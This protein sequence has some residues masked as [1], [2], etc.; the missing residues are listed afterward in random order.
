MQ[1]D[2]DVV[3]SNL[4]SLEGHGEDG[5]VATGLDRG[6]WKQLG[7]AA[8]KNRDALNARVNEAMHNG[9]A[10]LEFDGVA[11][12]EALLDALDAPV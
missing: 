5:A 2:D 9:P 1:V 8:A 7:E 4:A 11:L 10:S 3:Q 6:K 12:D